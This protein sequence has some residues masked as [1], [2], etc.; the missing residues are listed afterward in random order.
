[1][2]VVVRIPG[3]RG[4]AVRLTQPMLDRG[5]WIMSLVN[6]RSPRQEGYWDI[7]LSLGMHQGRT[8]DGH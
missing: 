8:A 5:W 4:E 2:R 6:I 7:I 1:M 3:R